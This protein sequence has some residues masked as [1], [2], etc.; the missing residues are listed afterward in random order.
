M[1]D[2]AQ[3]PVAIK[4]Q[5]VRGV[6]IRKAVDQGRFGV[7]DESVKVENKRSGHGGRSGKWSAKR[8]ML[9][10]GPRFG[11]RRITGVG[12]RTP[13]LVCHGLDFSRDSHREKAQPDRSR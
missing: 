13:R 12:L 10:H 7:E 4:G 3:K 1:T 8:K 2:A 5:V 6:D 11:K 9:G